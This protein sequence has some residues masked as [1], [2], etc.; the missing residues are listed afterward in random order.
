MSKV[1]DSFVVKQSVDNNLASPENLINVE[2]SNRG[3]DNEEIISI[4]PELGQT[5][6]RGAN[7]SAWRVFYKM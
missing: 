7:I 5:D 2:L 3:I 1:I 4:I 6:R